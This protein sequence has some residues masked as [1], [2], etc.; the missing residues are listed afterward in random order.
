M[1]LWEDNKFTANNSALYEDEGKVADYDIGGNG[2][3]TDVYWLRP[4]DEFPTGSNLAA[5]RL[6]PSDICGK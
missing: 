2:E 6:V 3:P 5:D 1:A 4:T